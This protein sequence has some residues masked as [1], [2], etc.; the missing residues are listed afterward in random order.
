[1]HQ[2]MHMCSVENVSKGVVITGEVLDPLGAE[3]RL[4]DIQHLVEIRLA[5]FDDFFIH[6]PF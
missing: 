6:G 1:M 2:P 4:V 3:M 5:G